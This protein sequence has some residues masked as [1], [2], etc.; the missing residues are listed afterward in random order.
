MICY[1]ETTVV[2]LDKFCFETT[3]KSEISIVYD[4][5]RQSLFII[6]YPGKETADEV[7]HTL[8]GLE[9]Q[10]QIDVKTAAT[11][12]RK[13]DG[14]LRLKHRQRVTL[15][16]DEFGVGAIGLLLAS[17]RAGKLA[18][19]LVGALT[20]SSRSKGRREAKAFLEN[21]LG[22]DDSGLAIL[23]TNADWEAVQSAIDHFDG[24]ELAVELTA[25]AEK[26]LAE[27]ASDEAVAA[28]VGEFVEIKEVTLWGADTDD[29]RCQSE[30]FVR[31]E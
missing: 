8:R 26:Q 20:G 6:A 24:E 16:K 27:I 4:E 28:A 11:I 14:K 19:A 25:K 18:G 12:Y 13:E 21:K 9:K 3:K 31:G 22:P 10:H 1:P 30:L 29:L 7:Y 5:R 23:V 15:W 17:T 2:V